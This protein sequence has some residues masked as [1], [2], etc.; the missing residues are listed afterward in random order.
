VTE[1][2]LASQMG[3]LAHEIGRLRVSL[4]DEKTTQAEIA[5]ALD[6]LRWGYQREVSLSPGDRPD[7]LTAEGIAIEVK[8]R[9]RKMEVW[10]QLLRY[11]A[12][13]RVRGILLAS[14]TAMGL[15]YNA[16]GKPLGFVSL[17]RAWL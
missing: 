8:L 6:A 13:D 2:A 3:F 17:G 11:A 10:R 4:T 12:H 7:F 14:N 9:A 16:G 1:V 5:R 15:P